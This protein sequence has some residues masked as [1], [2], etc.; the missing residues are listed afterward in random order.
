VYLAIS[1]RT[2][3]HQHPLT[4]LISNEGDEITHENLQELHDMAT[5]SRCRRS[6]HRPSSPAEYVLDDGS[7]TDNPIG[8][9]SKQLTAI[10]TRSSAWPRGCR[11]PSAA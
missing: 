1:A 6:R 9:A 2:S 4:T 5:P 7:M 11:R 10:S 8:L 3:A